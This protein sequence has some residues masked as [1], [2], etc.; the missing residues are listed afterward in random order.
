MCIH[1][2]YYVFYLVVV[3]L[4]D[5]EHQIDCQTFWSTFATRVHDDKEKS[6]DKSLN[7]DSVIALQIYFTAK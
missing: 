7:S 5:H 4:F 3:D 2:E 6:T 1:Y